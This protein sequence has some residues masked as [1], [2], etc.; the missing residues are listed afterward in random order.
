MFGILWGAVTALSVWPIFE[1]ISQK[2][3][4][5]LGSGNKNHALF[6]TMIFSLLFLAPFL[7]GIFELGE[8]Y[9][10][11]THYIANNTDNGVLNYP[12]WFEYLPMKEKVIEF[13]N[14]NI[15]TSAG[16]IE[17]VNKLSSGKLVLLFS[18]LWSQVLDRVITSIVM[19]ISFYFM[20]Q[21]GESI[22][23]KYKNVFS[24]WLSPRGLSHIENGILALRGTINGVVL[25]GVLEGILLAFPLMMGG[26]NSG[27]LIGL[28]AG[29]LGVIPLLMPVLI[30][31]CLIYIHMTGNTL[32]AIIGAVDLVIVWFIFENIIKPQMIS[33]K[34][35][36]NSVIILISMIGGMQLM[37]AVGLFLGPSI[38]SMAIGMIRDFLAGGIKA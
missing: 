20:L 25:V 10:S 5:F 8:L 15:A 1:K 32:W 21:N 31:P 17:A 9:K 37:G 2:N 14:S 33:K 12:Q 4:K 6:F 30:I 28:A 23:K 22:K 13:W 11:G 29:L 35:K 16:L 26:L 38:V 27:F 3:L 36:I 7:Y 34:V 19:I 24:Y 18:S